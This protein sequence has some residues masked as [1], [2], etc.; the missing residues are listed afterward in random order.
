MAPQLSTLWRSL[1]SYQIYG[2]NT[3]VGKTVI[4][5]I[6]CKALENVY[7]NEQT[8]YLKPI[9]TG[10]DDQSDVKHIQYFSPKTKAKCL[11]QFEQAVSP[12][13]AARSS[14][15][16]PVSDAHLRD[17][18]L[19]H[20][21]NCAQSGQGTLLV[22]TAGGVTSPAPSGTLQADLYQP[23][24]LSV[25]L[26]GDHSLGGI[27]ATI[28]AFESL[29]VRG[30]TVDALLQ[31][32]NLELQNHDYLEEY[33]K[34][35]GV[36]SLTIPLPPPRLPDTKEDNDSMQ[37]YYSKISQMKSVE[38][39][40]NHL[41]QKHLTRIGE[42]ERM[43]T[44]AYT[45]IWYPF[46]Q[47][48]QVS[49]E[50]IIPIDSACGDF[51]QVA[52]VSNKEESISD[53]QE[54][55]LTPA[56]DGSAS[57]W[58]QGL[59]HAL[60]ALSLAAAHAA[61]RYGHVIFAGNIHRPALDLAETLLKSLENS[62][63]SRVFFS[64]NGSTGM[65]VAIK[66]AF[67]ATSK[68]YGNSKANQEELGVIGLKGSYHGDTLGAMDCSEPGIFNEKVHWYKGRGYWFDFPRVFMKNG[69]WNIKIPN[70]MQEFI[71][72][73][74]LK[75][76]FTESNSINEISE[77]ESPKK[78]SFLEFSSLGQIFDLQSRKK[79]DDADLYRKY[80]FETLKLLTKD[81]GQKF[82]AVVMEPVLLGAAGMQLV[83][84]LFQ[85]ILIDVV[86]NSSI[87]DQNPSSD[88][89]DNK[90]WTGLPV[91][92]DEVF[93]GLYRLGRFSAA[94]FLDVEPDISVHAK[95]LT[96]GLV[97]LCCTVASETI[98]QSFMSDSKTDAL[99]HGHSYTAHPV[100]CHV[101]NTS[102]KMLAALDAGDDWLE[103]KVDWWSREEW[104]D[105][106]KDQ[107]NYEKKRK[108]PIWKLG[109]RLFD[110]R[111]PGIWSVWSY[112]FL[113]N[114]S[115][116]REISGII[117]LGSVLAITLEDKNHGY[118][119]MASLDLQKYLFESNEHFRIHVRALGNVLYIMASQTSESETLRKIEN[120]LESYFC[121][122]V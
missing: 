11:F 113:Y 43:S 55:I 38:R 13:V 109:K 8:W 20:L 72:T 103:G 90:A 98:Y 111:K 59:G 91:I 23:L 27:S 47:H 18:T 5:T 15:S 79:S 30:Y 24:R 3:N 52:P 73:A 101:A 37:E 82:G 46:T 60:P 7:P 89:A 93:T 78:A 64:D 88:S 28:S 17:L 35:H 57:W 102:L 87:F 1:K 14:P 6:L 95:L 44:D 58:T 116:N 107:Y 119:S 83:D 25:C 21:Q 77:N 10:P 94:K 29:H 33:F 41:S 16:K 112:E 117:S 96:G 9:S 51:F 34:M 108:S 53:S 48:K 69:Y 106:L 56:F 97:P 4:S 12:H 85:H 45:K 39:V 118:S 92:F 61:G 121:K 67:S 63:L 86:R 105:E 122:N 40:L 74:Q 65:E 115:Y 26:V 2:A 80:V 50:T 71:S 19:T 99:L 66:M 84:P 110:S 36:Q 114:L 62:R 42:L 22:E 32:E 76:S 120:T 81:Q 68:R 75:Y 54:G 49:P 104:I 70:V 31:F 100:G